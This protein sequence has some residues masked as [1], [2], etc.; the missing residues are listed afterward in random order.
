MA[1][2]QAR[3]WMGSPLREG[4]HH[5]VVISQARLFAHTWATARLSMLSDFPDAN[6]C[7]RQREERTLTS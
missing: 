5:V 6:S 1:V 4:Q 3:D 2:Q 7:P